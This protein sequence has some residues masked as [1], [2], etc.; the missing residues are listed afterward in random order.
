MN[1]TQCFLR[2]IF[3]KYSW[4]P[5][6]GIVVLQSISYGGTKFLSANWRHYM[7]SSVIDDYIP[8]IPAFILPYVLCYAHWVINFIMSA[9]T[10][11]QRFTRFSRAVMLSQIMCGIIFL[12]FPTTIVRPDV[13]LYNGVTGFLLKLIFGLDTPVNLFPSMHC[14]LSWFSWI[15]VRDCDNIPLWY[16]IFSFVFAIVVCISTV[17][18]KQHFFIDIIGGVTLA[19]L[20]WQFLRPKTK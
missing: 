6:A 14:L 13:S 20:C 3:P 10:G 19:E 5:L 7:P 15:A 18:I 1:K 4:F 11:E 16:Q 8:F 2:K 12:L 9:Q 17:A